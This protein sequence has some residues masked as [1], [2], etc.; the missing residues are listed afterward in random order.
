M[1]EEE[2]TKLKL[3]M[4]KFETK[5]T[6]TDNTVKR[7]EVKLDNFITGAD[8]KFSGKWVEKV[9][10]YGGG[11]VGTILVTALMALILK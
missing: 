4:V 8:K 7:I 2:I 10:V 6:S 3:S 9:L 1:P 5:L 11:I